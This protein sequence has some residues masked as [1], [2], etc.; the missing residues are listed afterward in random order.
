MRRNM[1]WGGG[2]GPG[3]ASYS[4]LCIYGNNVLIQ[5]WSYYRIGHY[6]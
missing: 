6:I 4:Y 3:K 2:W 1:V 5:V